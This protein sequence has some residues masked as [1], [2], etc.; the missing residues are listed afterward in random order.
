MADDQKDA[1]ENDPKR[2]IAELDN[3]SAKGPARDL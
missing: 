2:L 1:A 3:L